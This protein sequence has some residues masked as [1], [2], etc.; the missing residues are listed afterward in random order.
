MS[1]HGTSSAEM[2][3]HVSRM[4]CGADEMKRSS[5]FYLDHLNI[6]FNGIGIG[7]QYQITKLIQNKFD[8]ITTVT[9]V[10]Q[11]I[12]K[13]TLD[14][15]G[16]KPSLQKPVLFAS[17]YVTSSSTSA[18]GSSDSGDSDSVSWMQLA[19]VVEL[20]LSIELAHWLRTFHLRAIPMGLDQDLPCSQTNGCRSAL[21]WN[22]LTWFR[23][24]SLDQIQRNGHAVFMDHVHDMQ[25]YSV[26]KLA[27]DLLAA[28]LAFSQGT[29]TEQ[30]WGAMRSVAWKWP[31]QGD[32][33]WGWTSGADI[34]TCVF[35][36]TLRPRL[37]GCCEGTGIVSYIAFLAAVMHQCHAPTVL[38]CEN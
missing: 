8:Q 38:K 27:P 36:Q 9:A 17:K 30:T 28:S 34:S 4:H 20:S 22:N 35:V 2:V 29:W 1:D 16:L 14:W 15:T 11:K 10:F 12:R 21:L 25:K 19:A 3:A 26:M 13:R 37:W 33:G 18:S 32:K 24:V 5:V 31:G 23:T 7:I 6:Y